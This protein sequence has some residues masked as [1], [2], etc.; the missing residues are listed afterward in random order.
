MARLKPRYRIIDGQKKVY[1]WCAVFYDPDH[2]PKEKSTTLRTASKAIARRRLTALEKRYSLGLWD[3]WQNRSPHYGVMLSEAIEYFL[4]A[5][6]DKRRS[7]TVRSDRS[8]LETFSESLNPSIMLAHIEAEHIEDFLK[9]LKKKGRSSQ[10]CHT[11]ATRLRKFFKWCVAEGLLNRDPT[12]DVEKP[13]LGKKEKVAMTRE[14]FGRLVRAV[15]ADLVL[16]GGQLKEGEVR[17]MLD[18]LHVGIAT[19]MRLSEICNMRWSWVNHERGEITVRRA[20]GFIP[21]SGHERTIPITGT[22]RQIIE[23]LQVECSDENDDA[24]VFKGTR[25][26]KGD[27]GGLNPTYV[28]K[29]FL[30][31]RRVSKLPNGISFHSMRHSFCTWMIQA[32]VAVPT[33]QKLAG[34]ADI[35]T[36]MGYVHVARKDLHDAVEAVFG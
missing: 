7:S 20:N 33:V 24:F 15:E 8:A 34:H 1:A 31:Y 21:K 29:R 14:Q 35:K 23:R 30:H 9:N 22:A 26:R 36:T 6:V 13:R 32:G 2:A 28:S 3:A 16:Q 4:K 17:W 5:R 18:I 27:S 12:A 11:Y 25:G 10:T 19:G